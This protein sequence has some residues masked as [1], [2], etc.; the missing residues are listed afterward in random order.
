MNL[1]DAAAAQLLADMRAAEEKLL[2]QWWTEHPM[3]GELVVVQWEDGGLYLCV[4][5]GSDEQ[6]QVATRPSP[7]ARWVYAIG[8]QVPARH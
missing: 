6:S 2:L 5:A 8:Y 7:T 1:L 3:G 4:A